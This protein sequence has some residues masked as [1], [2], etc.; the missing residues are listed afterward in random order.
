MQNMKQ[1]EALCRKI[2]E[3]A[4]KNGLFDT[5]DG[6]L[7]E[8][9]EALAQLDALVPQDPEYDTA[10][11][12]VRNRGRVSISLVSRNCGITYKRA[13][14]LIERMHADGIVGPLDK[15]GERSV[16]G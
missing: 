14:E 16:I 2:V 8:L 9:K 10:V 12:A 1:L 4:K 3:Q 15:M 7:A 13:V 11:K 6:K 5:A